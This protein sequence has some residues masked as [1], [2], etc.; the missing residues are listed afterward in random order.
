MDRKLKIKLPKK[1]IKLMERFQ[2]ANFECFVVGGFIRDQLLGHL[3]KTNSVDLATNATPEEILTL[4]PDGKYENK[5]GTV[6]LP[7][8]DIA[9]ILELKSTD[10]TKGEFF[11]VT[12]YRSEQDYTDNRHPD[13]VAW[14]KNILEDLKRRDFTINALAYD[15]KILKDEFCGEKDLTGKIIRTVG[16]ATER[17]QE[18]ALRMLRAIRFSAE[19]GFKIEAKT[20]LAIAKN[21]SLLQEI[22]MERIRDEFFKIITSKNPASGVMLLKESGLLAFFLPELNEAFGVGQKSPERHHIYDVGTHL[23]KTMAECRTTDPV[24]RLAALLHDIGKPRVRKIDNRG[25][26]T[27]YNHEVVG[28]EMAFEIGKRLRLSNKDLKKLTKL[29]RFHQF[30]VTE[31]QTIKALRRFIRD[32]GPEYLDDILELRRADRLGSGAVESSWRT[33]LFIKKLAEAQIIPFTV[34]DLEI[35]GTEIIN[36]LKLTPGPQVGKILDYLF[37]QVENQKL[38]NTQEALSLFVKNNSSEL[39]EL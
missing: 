14:G 4:F 15:G 12:T 27:F 7:L 28:T 26:V 8:E 32:L 13:K 6:I 39:L 5:F 37:E 10:F 19:L 17:F 11:E 2:T 33:E 22:S 36:T 18:D 34:H 21:A 25:I 38:E 1:V 30:S 3:D 16:L 9:K 20:L 29:V 23:V 31:K 24:L 35:S